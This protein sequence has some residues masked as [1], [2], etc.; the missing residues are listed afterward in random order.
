MSED[1]H[2]AEATA[3]D[4]AATGHE[5]Q[6]NANAK[7]TRPRPIRNRLWDSGSIDE[8]ETVYNPTRKHLSEAAELR[9][10][11]ESHRLAA[12]AL[13]KFEDESCKPFKPALRAECPLVGAVT[14]ADDIAGGVRL[15][16]KPGIDPELVAAHMEC[17]V[18]FAAA[19][20]YAGM[21][22]CPLYLRKVVV[23]PDTGA[24]SVD[25]VSDDPA[26]AE[27]I[28]LLSRAHVAAASAAR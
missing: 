2:R 23:R 15:E 24:R 12:E 8:Y 22:H 19:Q 25:L 5:A 9:A 21:D 17:H 13:A 20:G 7:A 14:R 10:H 16:I 11:A 6:Y 3:S 27:R 4:R 28:R 18:A 26:T 1:Q